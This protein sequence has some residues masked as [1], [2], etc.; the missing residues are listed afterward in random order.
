MAASLCGC[1]QTVQ[2]FSA[3][4]EIWQTPPQSQLSRLAQTQWLPARTIFWW[5]QTSSLPF[6]TVVWG[7]PGLTQIMPV[8]MHILLSAATPPY[9]PPS[10]VQQYTLAWIWDGDKQEQYALALPAGLCQR[11][12][13][14]ELCGCCCGRLPTSRWPLQHCIE[15]CSSDGWLAPNPPSDQLAYP[16]VKISGLISGV[17]CSG[18]SCSVLNCSPYTVQ[19]S[20]CY[21]VVIKGSS[22]AAKRLAISGISSLYLSCSR[23]ILINFGAT[24]ACRTAC[25]LQSCKHLQL[26]MGTLPI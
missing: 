22:G 15:D 6:S 13:A 11:Q 7:Q 1:V 23:P 16:G 25:S 26:G 4:A 19:R 18:P 24:P 9:P 2:Q 14:T 3:L 10:P 20:E 8:E 21:S 12:S 17:L 5:T